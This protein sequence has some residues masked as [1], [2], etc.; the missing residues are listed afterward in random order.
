M[1]PDPP[2]H[3]FVPA[4]EYVT[5]PGSRV[6][7]IV[8]SRAVLE[9]R[10]DCFTVVRYLDDLPAAVAI[11]RIKSETGWPLAIDATIAREPDPGARDLERLRGYD[12]A[13][14]FLR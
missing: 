1:S 14:A 7:V 5:A 8:T 6:S 3:A 12:P 2:P 4:V 10:R 13:G 9:R 11:A